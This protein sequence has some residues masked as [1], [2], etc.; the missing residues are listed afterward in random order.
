MLARVE[1]T[2]VGLSYGFL[3]KNL[4]REREREG[5]RAKE[6]EK[7]RER[8]KENVSFGILR[9]FPRVEQN[10]CKQKSLEYGNL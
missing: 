7:E 1:G 2:A 10:I 9:I 5:G 4:Q 3:I 8:E 6:G